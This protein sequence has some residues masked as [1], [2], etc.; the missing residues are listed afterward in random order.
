MKKAVVPLTERPQ[1]AVDNALKQIRE[2]QAKCEHDFRLLEAWPLNESAVKNVFLGL[3]QKEP[4]IRYADALNLQCL[5]CSIVKVVP[6][7]TTCP[8]CLDRMN[9]EELQEHQKYFRQRMRG[10]YS[11]R[12]YSCGSC[13]LTI[14]VEEWKQ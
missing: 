9:K 10:Y 5:N 12:L 2:I 8:R 1:N 3:N 6:V 13:V 7:T 11:A 4:S 14:V